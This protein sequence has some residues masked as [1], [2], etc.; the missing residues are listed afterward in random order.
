M[1]GAEETTEG[2]CEVPE[3]GAEGG[4][5]IMWADITPAPRNAPVRSRA[6]SAS[7]QTPPRRCVDLVRP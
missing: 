7:R 4:S 3:K 1:A 5:R 6:K 2:E